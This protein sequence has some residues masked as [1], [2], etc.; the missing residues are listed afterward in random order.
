MALSDSGATA[1]ITQLVEVDGYAYRW[2]GQEELKVG[3]EVLLPENYVSRLR[4]GPGPFPG[5]V[6][7]IDSTYRGRTSAIVQK[8]PSSE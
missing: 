3:D 5:T 4:N 8:C 1:Q 7:A 6:T 2:N